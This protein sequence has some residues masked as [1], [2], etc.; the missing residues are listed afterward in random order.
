MVLAVCLAL[1]G[2]DAPWRDEIPEPEPTRSAVLDTI[3]A[4][5]VGERLVLTA[6]VATVLGDRAFV[7]RDVDLPDDGLLVLTTTSTGFRAP[8]LVSVE[9]TVRRFT[10]AGFKVPFGLSGPRPFQLFEGR[11]VLVAA[12]AQSL[13]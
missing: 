5:D 8:D 4:T 3:A 12:K 2:C 9:G 13:A 1:A 10:F 11:K 7:V 6:S